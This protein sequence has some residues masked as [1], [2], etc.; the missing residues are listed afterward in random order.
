MHIV[1]SIVLSA[2]KATLVE[3]KRRLRRSGAHLDAGFAVRGDFQVSLPGMDDM[4]IINFVQRIARNMPV[5][6]AER[7]DE[8]TQ[9]VAS[10]AKRKPEKNNG[11]VNT[12]GSIMHGGAMN[13]FKKGDKDFTVSDACVSCGTCE[14]AC[15][16]DVPIAQ[17]FSMMGEQT[18][19]LFNYPYICF[20]VIGNP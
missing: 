6:F 4:A 11:S 10:K 3:L 19:E 16:V 5:H 14:D 8:I 20:A 9:A 1:E 12:I 18:Q 17:L 2:T 15:P 7:K 13:M